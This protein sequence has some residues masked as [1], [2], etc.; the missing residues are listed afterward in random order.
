MG[1]QLV[2][3]QHYFECAV[4][5]HHDVDDIDERSYVVIERYGY[6]RKNR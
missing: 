5:V 3:V 2:T 4:R 1:R 6:D